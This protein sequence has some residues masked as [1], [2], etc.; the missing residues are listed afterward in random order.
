MDVFIQREYLSELPIYH[1]LGNHDTYYSY[2]IYLNYST[3]HPYYQ[4]R[5]RFYSELFD[6]KDHSSK[7]LGLLFLDSTSIACA[8]DMKKYSN[9][10]SSE[11][12]LAYS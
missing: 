9:C 5:P 7:R 10:S 3:K 11:K 12:D 2:D 1:V 4:R 8:G 6:L